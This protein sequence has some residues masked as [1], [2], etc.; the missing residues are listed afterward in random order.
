M[1]YRG[2]FAKGRWQILHSKDF[3]VGFVSRSDNVQ[4]LC[5]DTFCILQFNLLH[6]SPVTIEYTS[7]RIT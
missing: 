4:K 5:Q 2:R 6:F 1:I 7:L 3:A